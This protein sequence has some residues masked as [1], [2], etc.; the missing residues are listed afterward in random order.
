MK[1][2]SL[3]LRSDYLDE[4][5]FVWSFYLTN[6]SAIKRVRYLSGCLL[7]LIAINESIHFTAIIYELSLAVRLFCAVVP[8]QA[9]LLR[10][11]LQ[12][13]C[14]WPVALSFTWDFCSPQYDYWPFTPAPYS[15]VYR[16]LVPIELKALRVGSSFYFW[17]VLLAAF[18]W[19]SSFQGKWKILYPQV[20][21]WGSHFPP[22]ADRLQ[23]FRRPGWP[24]YPWP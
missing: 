18:G 9:N 4:G 17:E 23:F 24:F 8:L 2:Q 12:F 1:Q 3:S 15:S 10:A 13:C 11:I 7:F 5:W 20:L 16:T 14:C 19:F 21:S 6:S 22:W